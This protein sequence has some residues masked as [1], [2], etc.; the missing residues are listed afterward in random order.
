LKELQIAV[1]GMELQEMEPL[2]N[3]NKLFVDDMGF[4][5]IMFKLGYLPFLQNKE[6]Y[7]K[8]S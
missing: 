8:K 4:Q 6:M 1:Y 2:E 7:S 3:E 5:Q